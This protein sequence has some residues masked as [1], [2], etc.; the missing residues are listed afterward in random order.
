MEICLQLTFNSVLFLILTLVWKSALVR[1]HFLSDFVFFCLLLFLLL[2]LFVDPICLWHSFLYSVR[3][4][5]SVLLLS[6]N[7]YNDFNEFFYV[8]DAKM[9]ACTNKKKSTTIGMKKTNTFAE[10]DEWKCGTH[11]AH[12]VKQ[13]QMLSKCE[14][15]RL[16]SRH[17][18][19]WWQKNPTYY[20]ILLYKSFRSTFLMVRWFDLDSHP[21]TYFVQTLHQFEELQTNSHHITIWIHFLHV[22]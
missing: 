9:F 14:S 4:F 11:I 21:F 20:A 15:S 1:V 22:N 12:I 16:K 8:S 19:I 17:G 3:I 18:W 10:I 5:F 6:A 7:T 2:L 13:N